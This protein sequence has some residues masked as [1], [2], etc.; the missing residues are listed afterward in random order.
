MGDSRRF[1]T[2]ALFVSPRLHPITL[3]VNWKRVPSQAILLWKKSK[4]SW[5][6]LKP[7]FRHVSLGFPRLATRDDNG[8]KLTFIDF[9]T[10]ICD[11]VIK[12][13]NDRVFH[14][15]PT[16][17]SWRGSPYRRRGCVFIHH[18]RSRRI[19][20]FSFCT[21]QIDGQA[22]L[23]TKD[24]ESKAAYSSLAQSSHFQPL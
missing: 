11:R 1:L 2:S 22:S 15:H 3:E 20:F 16:S 8:L 19:H 10:S 17:F 23:A 12:R 4:I 9:S 21:P 13:W 6:E 24:N 14:R 18:G 5:P 7:R